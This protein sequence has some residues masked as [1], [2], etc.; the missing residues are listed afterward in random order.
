MTIPTAAVNWSLETGPGVFPARYTARRGRWTW[1]IINRRKAGA[2]LKAWC[3][4]VLVLDEVRDNLREAK[5][6]AYDM[7][8]AAEKMAWSRQPG[9]VEYRASCN[10]QTFRAMP[11][12]GGYQVFCT[13]GGQTHRGPWQATLVEAKAAVAALVDRQFPPKVWAP[14]EERPDPSRPGYCPDCEHCNS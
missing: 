9:G 12:G 14:V 8:S 7:L 4:G 3:D 10:G 11:F 6:A 2:T 5:D 1:R 13:R